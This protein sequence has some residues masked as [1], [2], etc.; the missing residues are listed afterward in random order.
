[1]PDSG[2]R[3]CCDD[4]SFGQ[5]D[6][7]HQ[8]FGRQARGGDPLAVEMLAVVEALIRRRTGVPA[9]LDEAPAGAVIMA[10]ARARRLNAAVGDALCAALSARDYLRRGDPELALPRVS[11][12]GVALEAARGHWA[13]L[14]P[15]FSLEG[16]DLDRD[17][18]LAGRLTGLLTRTAS[19]DARGARDLHRLLLG[20]LRDARCA[21][22]GLVLALGAPA[23][24]S[25]T[26]L[27]GLDG[28]AQATP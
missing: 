13:G 8:R 23:D 9:W 11:A 12:V 26:D 20:G 7:L 14:G 16:F 17:I 10:R 28:Q 24:A 19:F 27:S 15:G 22:S 1:M 6:L 3:P 21:V 25:G 2:E 5:L 4:L 18:G